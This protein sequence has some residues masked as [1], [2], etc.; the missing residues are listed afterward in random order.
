MSIVAGCDI[1]SVTGKTVILD[2]DEIISTS[3][4]P[5]RPLPAKTASDTMGQALEKVGLDIEEIK[6]VVG[7]GYGRV[8]IPFASK[9]V[10]EIACHAKGAAWFMETAG[11]LIDIGG[12]DCKAIAL[13]EKVKGRVKNFVMNDKCA[14]GTGRFLE[15]MAKV[16]EIE[17]KNIGPLAMKAQKIVPISSQCS[18]FAESEVISLIAEENDISDILAGVCDSVAGRIV[19]LVGKVGLREDVTI[20]GGVGK[21]IGVVKAIERR[22]G[23]EMKNLPGD[24]Q[25]VGALGAALI[26]REMCLQ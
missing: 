13:D 9:T 20:S 14:A 10:S 2:G 17:P 24:S 15:V 5:S 16:F 18:V 8:K 26:A 12:Q 22:L 3:I 23:M 19:S 21:N 7:T 11:T 6:Y 1:G 4:I 25:I